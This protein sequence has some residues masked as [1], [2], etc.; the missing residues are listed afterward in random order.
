LYHYNNVADCD[1]SPT[2]EQIA[3]VAMSA[4]PTTEAAGRAAG[5][6]DQTARSTGSEV[7]E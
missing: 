4:A 7:I 3:R 1:D 2:V 5:V 6:G